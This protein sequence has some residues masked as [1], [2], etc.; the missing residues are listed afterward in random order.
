MGRFG[1]PE[2]RRA[3]PT[4]THATFVQDAKDNEAWEGPKKDQPYKKTGVKELSPLC[5]LPL[6]CLIWDILPDLMH[7][8]SGI[9]KRHIMAILRGKRAPAGVKPR[10]KYT[11][12]ENARLQRDHKRVKDLLKSWTLTEVPAYVH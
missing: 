10:K 11:D 7:I 3:P 12:L 9:W 6:F 4:R 8:I 1:E 2:I 5:Y